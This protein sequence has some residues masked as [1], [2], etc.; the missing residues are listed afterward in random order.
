MHTAADQGQRWALI[1]VYHIY[2]LIETVDEEPMYIY[3]LRF[4]GLHLVTFCFPFILLSF[5]HSP[6][7]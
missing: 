5:L 2:V 4:L 1:I 6:A 7:H 3:R